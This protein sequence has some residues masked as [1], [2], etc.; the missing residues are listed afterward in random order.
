MG[1]MRYAAN[2]GSAA[3]KH[4]ARLLLYDKNIADNAMTIVHVCAESAHCA[5]F[6]DYTSF[7]AAEHGAAKFLHEVVNKF[8]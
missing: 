6:D 1:P 3:F 5:R 4:P 8:W 2:H 7:K